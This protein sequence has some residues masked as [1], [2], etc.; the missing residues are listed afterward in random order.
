MIHKYLAFI[1]QG[2]ETPEITRLLLNVFRTRAYHGSRQVQKSNPAHNNAIADLS[3]FDSR[4]VTMSIDPNDAEGML[5]DGLDTQL[6]IYPALLNSILNLVTSVE[7][8][9]ALLDD[10]RAV[11]STFAPVYNTPVRNRQDIDIRLD[12]AINN[13]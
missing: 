13:L 4:L 11:N 1:V 3:H 5:R 12:A 10:I 2:A 7:M 9:Y 6:N 8:G